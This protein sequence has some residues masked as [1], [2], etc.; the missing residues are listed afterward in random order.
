LENK[1]FQFNR[2]GVVYCGDW[3]NNKPHGFGKNYY[4]NGGYY[5]GMFIN[6]LPQGFGRFIN[7]NGDYYQGDIFYGRG[8]G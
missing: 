7:T 5:E 4:P 2:S 3:F 1:Y 8:N 6:G